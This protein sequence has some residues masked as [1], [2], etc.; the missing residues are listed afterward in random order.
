LEPA[1]AVFHL[2]AL[3]DELPVDPMFLVAAGP[4]GKT[5][6]GTQLFELPSWFV[7]V[8]VIAADGQ[9]HWMLQQRVT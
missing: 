2:V 7:T 8:E 4:A 3:T 5:V 9:S 6:A 1:K